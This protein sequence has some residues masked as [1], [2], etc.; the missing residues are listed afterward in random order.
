MYLNL[1][2]LSSLL[3]VGMYAESDFK[4]NITWHPVDTLKWTGQ[5]C[6]IVS[7]RQ[8]KRSVAS[9]LFCGTTLFAEKICTHLDRH[10]HQRW[11]VEL[12]EEGLQQGVALATR[13]GSVVLVAVAQNAGIKIFPPPPLIQAEAGGEESSDKS[14]ERKDS[15]HCIEAEGTQG[16]YHLK[17][18][19]RQTCS[20]NKGATRTKGA[21]ICS[22]VH[23]QKALRA[24]IT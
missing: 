15:Q 2:F 6:Q 9:N 22:T 1:P 5:G 7:Y 19:D 17:T 14:E 3:H 24:G 4:H 10:P 23:K 11:S 16:R 21:K 20:R 13:V 12:G 8:G 18:K